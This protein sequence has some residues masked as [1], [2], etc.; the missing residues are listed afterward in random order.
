VT[1]AH[2]LLI[3]Q[4]GSPVPFWDQWDAEGSAIY[5]PYMNGSLTAG[6]FFT[7]HN[8][9]RIPLTRLVGFLVWQA[10]GYWDVILQMVMNALLHAA[11]LGAF[12]YALVRRLALPVTVIVGIFAAAVL[13]LPFG[14]AN[15]LCGFQSQFYFLIL[16]SVIALMLL[17]ECPAFSGRW[18]LGTLVGIAAHF[19]MASGALAILAA[20]AISLMQLAFWQR[21]GIRE[22]A[23]ASI[24]FALALAMLWDIP[25]LPDHGTLKAQSIQQFLAALVMVA[26]WPLPPLHWTLGSAGAIVMYL[27]VLLLVARLW[28]DRPGIADGRWLL[29]ALATWFGLQFCALAYG[30]AIAPTDSRYRDILVLAL[31]TSVACGAYIALTESRRRIC[32][33]TLASLFLALAAIGSAI[34]PLIAELATKREQNEQ[35]IRNVRNYLATGDFAEIDKPGQQIPYPSPLRLHEL[36]SDPQLRSILPPALS[37]KQDDPQS[38]T[39]W[40][41]ERV[42]RA[43]LVG[44]PLLIPLGIGLLVLAAAGLPGLRRQVGDSKPGFGLAF[45]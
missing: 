38:P 44:G 5:L 30:R 39:Q 16:F 10:S 14:W 19:S 40:L 29:L 22:W 23:A 25:S 2:L 41:V 11:M 26:S 6:Q 34:N 43:A 3:G 18:W 24:H 45:D 31:C 9:H 4:L 15:A 1:G 8:E 33:V 27:P 35:Q 20:A 36:L 21:R 32:A 13:A 42:K 28:R 17:S 37:G 7:Q 12:L